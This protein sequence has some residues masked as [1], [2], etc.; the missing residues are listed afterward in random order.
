MKS[1]FIFLTASNAQNLNEKEQKNFEELMEVKL[2][3]CPTFSCQNDKFENLIYCH[4]NSIY[5]PF[6]V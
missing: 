3:T 5:D 4:K 2:K 6:D 1:L